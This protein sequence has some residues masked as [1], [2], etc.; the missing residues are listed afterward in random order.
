M[1]DE[2]SEDFL[3][4]LELP[5][6]ETELTELDEMLRAARRVLER[7]WYVFG[8]AYKKKIP[9]RGTNGH[10]DALNSGNAAE[11]LQSTSARADSLSSMSI[12]ASKI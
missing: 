3:P 12:T 2:L 6:P 8:C 10:N 1:N 5:P 7:G 11:I 9:Y 4:T